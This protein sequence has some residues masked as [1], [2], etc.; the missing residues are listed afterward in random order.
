MEETK[1]KISD[2]VY[3]V[4]VAQTQQE[5]TTGLSKT[6]NLPKNEGMIFMYDQEEEQLYFTMADTS[7]DLDIIGISSEGIVKDVYSVE[8]YSEDLIEFNNVQYVLE[9]NYD[10]GIQPGD[11]IEELD[12]SDNDDDYTEEEKEIASKSKMLVLDENGDV[13]M[14]LLG[15]E[16]IFSRIS[17]RKFIKAAIKAFKNEADEDYIK[18][19]KMVF[20]E[21]DAQDNR[22][23]EYV[24]A[25]ERKKNDE[26]DS[27]S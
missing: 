16:R 5:K 22:D 20:K 1:I 7:I 19:A 8:A 9:V 10:S 24:K 15:G 27:E 4:K 23:P 17:T 14:K 6:K 12:D 11:E 18:V 2:K 3:K 21:L 26:S 25:P 13:Q